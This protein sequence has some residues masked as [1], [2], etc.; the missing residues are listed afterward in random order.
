[1]ARGPASIPGGGLAI[2]GAAGAQS[3]DRALQLL[4]L[5]G[6]GGPQGRGLAG[7]VAETDLTRPTARR[8]L[9]ALI[10]ARLVE[11]DPVTRRYHLGP[12][13]YL[14]GTFAAPRH[15]LLTHAA[16]SL[17]RLAQQTGDSVFLS[18]PQGDHVLCLHREE[19]SFPIRTYALQAGDRNPLGAGAGGIA[20]LAAM[21]PAEAEAAL[22]RLTPAL[23]ARFGG[24]IDGLLADVAQAR[25]RGWA[26]NPGRVVPGSWGIGCALRWP[27][28]RPAAALSLAAIESRLTPD[29]Q[30]TIAA[31]MLAEA[32]RIE[33]S[34]SAHF[35]PDPAGALQAAPP[36]SLQKESR[37]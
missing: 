24:P 29:R 4:S 7:L 10:A 18:V 33:A 3:V 19:G 13:A 34:L 20:L 15:G 36:R 25:A 9:I 14:L 17:R 32:T 5:V 27:D 26:V 12:E 21:P 28:G 2:A 37:A 16:D 11:Q 1:M 22:A 23:T 30:A 31:A 6:R 8:L 35:A